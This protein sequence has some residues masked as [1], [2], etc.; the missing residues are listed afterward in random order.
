MNRWKQYFESLLQTEI[1][2]IEKESEREAEEVEQEMY[3]PTLD[4]VR[5]IIQGIKNGK[6][7]GIDTI[8]V[9]LIK[10]AG[11]K[12]EQK[13]YNL[14]RKI[15]NDEHMPMDWEEGIIYPIYKKGDRSVC[16]NYRG[17]TLVNV[18]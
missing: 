1:E 3:E 5:Y 18:T 9:E 13:I 11:A 17:I 4:E 16:S 7:P 14:I 15:W 10:N 6:A 2:P 8:T 12:M